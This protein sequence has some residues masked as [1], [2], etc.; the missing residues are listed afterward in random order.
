LVDYVEKASSKPAQ[1]TVDVPITTTT[2]NTYTFTG[3][4]NQT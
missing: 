1:P 4:P 2:V 3:Q